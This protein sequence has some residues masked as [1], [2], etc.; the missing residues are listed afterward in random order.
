MTDFAAKPAKVGLGPDGHPKRAK[1]S[2]QLAPGVLKMRR[3]P[4]TKDRP[5]RTP[6][7]LVD[8]L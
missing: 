4:V 2:R 6:A 1:G 5:A 7:V 3:A 8:N